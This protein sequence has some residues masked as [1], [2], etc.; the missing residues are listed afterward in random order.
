[1]QPTTADFGAFTKT[2]EDFR[3]YKMAEPKDHTWED[4]VVAILSVNHY[5]LEK[6]Y[7]TIAG[8]RR[9]GIVEPHNLRSWGTEEIAARLIRAGYDRGS[10]M[11]TLF[12]QRLASLGRF[13]ES[14]GLESCELVLS[15]KNSSAIADLLMPVNGIGPSVLKNFLIMRGIEV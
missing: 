10:F 6:T 15:S 12:A 2:S 1:M 7:L 4:L 5:S 9:E 14:H 8:L 13:L 11:T 3:I